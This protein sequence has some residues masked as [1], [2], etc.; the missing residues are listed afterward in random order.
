MGTAECNKSNVWL[1]DV[2]LTRSQR[3]VYHEPDP[4]YRLVR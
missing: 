4:H 2:R 3:G 1:C